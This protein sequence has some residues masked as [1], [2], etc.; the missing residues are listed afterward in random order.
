MSSP[1]CANLSREASRAGL[2]IGPVARAETEKH[3]HAEEEVNC[4]QF[5]VIGPVVEVDSVSVVVGLLVKAM[6]D[7]VALIGEAAVEVLSLV[8]V[9]VNSPA[10]EVIGSGFEPASLLVH[11]DPWL[12]TCSADVISCSA[13]EIFFAFLSVVSVMHAGSTVQVSLVSEVKVCVVE[14]TGPEVKAGH[15]AQV[16]VEASDPVLNL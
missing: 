13:V 3:V 2:G 11:V 14:I 6:A 12:T 16:V 1:L 15:G 4:S 5:E 7:V 9:T 10:V 8:V